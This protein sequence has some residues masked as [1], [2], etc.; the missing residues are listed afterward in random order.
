MNA[1]QRIREEIE[2]ATER[3][4]HVWKS[5]SEGRDA[6]LAAELKELDEHI[7]RLWNEHRAERARLRF[8]DREK[9]VAR[10]RMEERLE[11]AA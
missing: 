3:R 8:G 11:R 6:V 10:A 4:R 7:D 2:R 9:I 1:L 5:L